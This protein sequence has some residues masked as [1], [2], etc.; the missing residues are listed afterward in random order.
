MLEG[1][2][3]CERCSGTP[4]I[5]WN[6]IS[7]ERCPCI[8]RELRRATL[9]IF[10]VDKPALNSILLSRMNS[11]TLLDSP[12]DKVRPHVAA[13]I[14]KASEKGINVQHSTCYRL[15]EKFVGS[16][17]DGAEQHGRRIQDA[18]LLILTLGVG[19]ISVGKIPGI[20]G[21]C[22]QQ[23][24]DR[25]EMEMRPTWVILGV[26]FNQVGTRYGADLERILRSFQRVTIK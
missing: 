6:G 8:S 24:L 14:L 9:G 19:E 12:L 13:V 22:V 7:Y 1:W 3:G 16:E 4:G 23:V 5:L 20:I 11:N 21:E 15:F 17:V 10:A 26:D 2:S 25:R 18:D